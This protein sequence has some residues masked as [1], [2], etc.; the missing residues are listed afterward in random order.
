M[1][2][3]YLWTTG[4][5]VVIC[6]L[7]EF[8]GVSEATLSLA[9]SS[10]NISALHKQSQL[11]AQLTYAV[12]QVGRMWFYFGEGSLQ[13]FLMLTSQYQSTEDIRCLCMIQRNHVL[14]CYLCHIW[15]L[16]LSLEL[17]LHLIIFV[18]LISVVFFLTIFWHLT[19]CTFWWCWEVCVNSVLWP[20]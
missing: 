7:L 6:D 13:A 17:F 20:T 16:K 19:R 18:L 1:L 12:A 15:N 4:Y 3:L 9:C 8:V 11:Y 14:N 2:I 5:V 10:L